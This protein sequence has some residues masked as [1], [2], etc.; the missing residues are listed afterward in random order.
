MADSFPPLKADPY[1]THPPPSSQQPA[2]EVMFYRLVLYKAHHQTT[3]VPIKFRDDGSTFGELGSWVARQRREYFKLPAADRRRFEK[4]AVEGDTADKEYVAKADRARKK[5]EKNGEKRG[6]DEGGGV[7]VEGGGEGRAQGNDTKGDDDQVVEANDVNAEDDLNQDETPGVAA[8]VDANAAIDGEGAGAGM[9]KSVDVASVEDSDTHVEAMQNSADARSGVDVSLA[10]TAA[11]FVKPQTPVDTP[12]RK[13][14]GRPPVLPELTPDRISALLAVG[15]HFS[16]REDRWEDRYKDLLNFRTQH[17][18]CNVPTAKSSLGKWVN[19]QRVLYQRERDFLEGK[20]TDLAANKR[21]RGK[22]VPRIT[23]EK[24]E[25]LESI[26]FKW[27][28]KDRTKWEDRFDELVAFRNAHGHTF[29]PQHYAENKPL[30]KWVTK[31]RYEHGRWIKGEKSQ[32]TQARL[33]R[34]ESVGFSFSAVKGSGCPNLQNRGRRANPDK[35]ATDLRELTEEDKARKM[36]ALAEKEIGALDAQRDEEAEREAAFEAVEEAE[37]E[38]ETDKRRKGVNKWGRDDE[39]LAEMRS[40]QRNLEKRALAQAQRQQQQDEGYAGLKEER[41]RRC[42]VEVGAIAERDRYRDELDDRAQYGDAVNTE[43]QYNRY[44]QQ[45]GVEEP[46]MHMIGEAGSA[47][48]TARAEHLEAHGSD[49]YEHVQHQLQHRREDADLLARAAA[50]RAEAD[51]AGYH[52]ERREMLRRERQPPP[53]AQSGA[54]GGAGDGVP[55]P[56]PAGPPL[57]EEAGMA[58]MAAAV[59]AYNAAALPPHLQTTQDAG[60]AAAAAGLQYMG[61]DEYE[62]DAPPPPLPAT[63]YYRYGQ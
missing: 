48:A 22:F 11:G 23:A 40:Q 15:F 18:H 27:R 34:L 21:K 3:A 14:K 16:V 61:V 25:K 56:G 38:G 35:D 7:A 37:K 52:Q 24:R 46:P 36:A 2:W 29:V 19:E 59:E 32:M 28:I 1:P 20:R 60:T 12:K 47:G 44:R 26:G 43:D 13:R 41:Y 57:P 51:M 17:G 30:G 9:G 5:E 39:N 45:G 53:Y 6:A 63:D 8:E 33:D 62:H 49:R 10:T 4:M 58:A 50:I 42:G 31:M 55:G 54:D